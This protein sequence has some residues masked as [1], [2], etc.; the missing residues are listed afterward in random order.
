MF[1]M[2]RVLRV[3]FNAFSAFFVLDYGG[4]SATICLK[5]RDNFGG[6]FYSNAYA[7]NMFVDRKNCFELSPLL[8]CYFCYY[9]HYLSLAELPN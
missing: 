9:C 5:F 6:L 1:V 8:R 2:S 4:A 3:N 7:K